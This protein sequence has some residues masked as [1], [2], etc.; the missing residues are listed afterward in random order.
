MGGVEFCKKPFLLSFMQAYNYGLN[1]K[2]HNL[3]MGGS[4]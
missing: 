2:G 1:Y 3:S 4:A